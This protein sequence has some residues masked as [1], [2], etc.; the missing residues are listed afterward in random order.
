VHLVQLC[1]NNPTRRTVLPC[2]LCNRPPQAGWRG[3]RCRCCPPRHHVVELA[4]FDAR[5]DAVLE[6][7]D[8]GV[9]DDGDGA[10]TVKVE[11]LAEE[12]V[13]WAGAGGGFAEEDPF[14]GADVVRF[15]GLDFG[16]ECGEA[17][18]VVWVTKSA[19]LPNRVFSTSVSNTTNLT[20]GEPDSQGS[21]DS[22]NVA[23]PSSWRHR[24]EFQMRATL[25]WLRVGAF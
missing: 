25:P 17:S 3:I 9:G 21:S 7:C 12:G 10:G 4:L 13:V 18:F 2:P 14:F 22:E 6:G 1:T 23:L 5:L 16:V 15:E 24:Y 8:D 11:V 20:A 19:L